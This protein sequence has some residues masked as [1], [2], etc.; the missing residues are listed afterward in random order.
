MSLELLTRKMSRCVG[1]DTIG[2]Q[3][4]YLSTPDNQIIYFI[5]T[6][7]GRQLSIAWNG[8]ESLGRNRSF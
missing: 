4:E 8:A 7:S 6:K 1:H 5:S 3:F 2:V